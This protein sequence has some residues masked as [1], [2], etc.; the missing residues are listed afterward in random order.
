MP[1]AHRTE[2]PATG[3]DRPAPGED[4]VRVT[5]RVRL[6]VARLGG[7]IYAA[8]AITGSGRSLGGRE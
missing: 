3:L 1:V 7:A 8:D 4:L 6:S 5:E 2:R